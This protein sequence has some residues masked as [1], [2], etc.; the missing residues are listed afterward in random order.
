MTYKLSKKVVMGRL[1]HLI[2]ME[3]EMLD[4]LEGKRREQKIQDIEK[5]EKALRW[6]KKVENCNIVDL[7]KKFHFRMC[8]SR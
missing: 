4:F 6:L 3:L 1:K 8:Y 5:K 2:E 7:Q